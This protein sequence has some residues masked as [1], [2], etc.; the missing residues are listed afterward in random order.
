[1]TGTPRT[2]AEAAYVVS[3]DFART[4]EL[5]LA[6]AQ[7]ELA[8][9]R[10]ER[11]VIPGLKLQLEMALHDCETAQRLRI[12]LNEIVQITPLRVDLF[13]RARKEKL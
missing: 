5:E 1:M 12:L 11:T 10:V 4:L 13:Q 9:L 8:Q 6:A 3:V 7:K 2:D